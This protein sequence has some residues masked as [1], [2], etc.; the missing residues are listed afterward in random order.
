M[1]AL[2]PP[3]GDVS[4][5]LACRGGAGPAFRARERP[6]SREVFL[7]Q[8]QTGA[9]VPGAEEGSQADSEHKRVRMRMRLRPACRGSA[10]GSAPWPLQFYPALTCLR[11]PVHLTASVHSRGA[12]APRQNEPR[13]RAD[14]CGRRSQHLCLPHVRPQGHPHLWVC[15][16]SPW[17]GGAGLVP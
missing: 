15:T 16:S 3:F 2:G 12:E 7:S 6:D 11:P 8:G 5:G 10:A 1:R 17:C 4:G 14:T 13:T 9:G